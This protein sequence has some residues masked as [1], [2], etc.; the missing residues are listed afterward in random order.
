MGGSFKIYNRQKDF[1]E[2]KAT[3]RDLEMKQFFISTKEPIE[4]VEKALLD[5]LREL[6]R[7]RKSIH[8]RTEK[9]ELNENN[10]RVILLESNDF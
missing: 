3:V 10:E 5:R 8:I 1:E 2:I 4:D 6:N 7:F 9:I